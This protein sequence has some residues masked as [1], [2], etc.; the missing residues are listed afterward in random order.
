MENTQDISCGKMLKGVYPPTTERTSGP[1]CRKSAISKPM[2]Y[3]YLDLTRSGTGAALSWEIISPLHGDFL[4]HNF[5]ASLKD[6]A[7]CFLSQILMEGVP[8]RYYLTSRA[9][10]GIL[11]RASER[12]KELPEVLRKA[13]ERQ[14][15]ADIV[16]T[17]KGRAESP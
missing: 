7:V 4:T 11:R 10:A 17:R 1:S 6:A 12:G 8:H 16:S 13:L 5:S 14:A 2:P 15:Q 9:C 3:L